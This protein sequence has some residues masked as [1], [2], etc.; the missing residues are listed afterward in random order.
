MSSLHPLG[1]AAARLFLVLICLGGVAALFLGPAHAAG[2]YYELIDIIPDDPGQDRRYIVRDGY[3][4]LH[5]ADYQTY[6]V[7]MTWSPPPRTSDSAGFTINLNITGEATPNRVYMGV[8]IGTPT[9]G[10]TFDKDPPGA[11]I[12]VPDAQPGGRETRSNQASI[13]VTPSTSHGDGAIIEL[14]IGAYYGYGVTYRYRVSATPIE[15]GDE[16]G[17]DDD[18][19]QAEGPLVVIPHCPPDIVIGE[20]PSLNCYLEISG[21]RR[22]T[23]DPVEVI[24]PGMLDQF[25]NHANGIQVVDL[26]GAQDAF[27]WD[28]V[29][30]WGFFVYACQAPNIGANCYDNA[31]V[32]G[33]AFIEAIVQQ[34]GLEPVRVRLDFNVIGRD[35]GDL[36]GLGEEVRIGSRWIASTFINNESGTPASTTILLDWLSARWT[37]DPVDGGYVRIHSVW[38]PDE[39]LH[40]ENGVL[41]VGPIRPEWQSAM[42]VMESTGGGYFT[43]FRNLWQP[44]L[45]LNVESGQLQATAIA[46]DWISADWWLLR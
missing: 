9:G 42:W 13:H 38:K 46:P 36:G 18:T 44:D 28:R 12:S 17:G 14:K 40:V 23:A 31:A 22:N 1:R 26:D 32:P 6:S 45:Y 24:V 8:G 41:E 3:I 29:Y 34:R 33:P 11:D 37:L 39:Y 5:D 21:F 4:K 10:F 43:R 20:L 15:G 27:N 35:G 2:P 16:D 25:G 19:Q 7:E 30:N